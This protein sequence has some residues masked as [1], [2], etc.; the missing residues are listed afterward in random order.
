M[1][2]VSRYASPRLSY[3]NCGDRGDLAGTSRG[4][5]AMVRG[6]L[7]ALRLSYATTSTDHSR[8]CE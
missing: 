3:G 2:T 6:E 4:P 1:F 5:R 8:A 7:R